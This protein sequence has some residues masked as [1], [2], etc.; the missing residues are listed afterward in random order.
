MHLSSENQA[1]EVVLEALACEDGQVAG[2]RVVVGVGQASWID[3]FGVEHAELVRVLVHLK[4]KEAD[5]A[6][7]VLLVIVLLAFVE[8][9]K[10]AGA[11]LAG[12]VVYCKLKGKELAEVLSK[13]SAGIVA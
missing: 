13:C 11:V 10:V 4:N 7:F 2:S 12:V 1:H 5:A 3:K 8:L 9:L 6:T